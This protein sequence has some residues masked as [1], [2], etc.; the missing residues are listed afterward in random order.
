MYEAFEEIEDASRDI[1]QRPYWVGRHI[2]ERHRGGN[3]A[4]AS[5]HEEGLGLGVLL[6]LRY[7]S[8][9][10]NADLKEQ[11]AMD[12]DAGDLRRQVVVRLGEAS[13][14]E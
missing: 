9:F 13:M 8:Q 7:R 3:R 14:R 5:S 12:L 10:H 6:E 1:D 11:A 2:D 4:L